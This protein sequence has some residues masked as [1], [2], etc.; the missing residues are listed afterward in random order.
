MKK[1][2]LLMILI[3]LGCGLDP[4]PD[5]ESVFL[6]GEH[7]VMYHNFEGS[8]HKTVLDLESVR[9][10]NTITPN[11]SYAKKKETEKF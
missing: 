9:E 8:I 1:V 4:I 11:T 2:F 5:P 6:I 3:V 7:A 10:N